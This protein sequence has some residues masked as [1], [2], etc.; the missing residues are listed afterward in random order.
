ME[1]GGQ[2]IGEKWLF[3]SRPAFRVGEPIVHGGVAMLLLRWPRG[4]GRIGL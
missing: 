3:S 1:R 4:E 2:E